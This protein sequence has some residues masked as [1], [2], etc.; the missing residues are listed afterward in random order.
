MFSVQRETKATLA[1]KNGGRVVAWYNDKETG[2]VS[3]AV[4]GDRAKLTPVEARNL[5]AWLLEAASTL[6]SPVRTLNDVRRAEGLPPL[7]SRW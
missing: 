3:I 2:A 7:G 5:A 6:E 1:A 4:P